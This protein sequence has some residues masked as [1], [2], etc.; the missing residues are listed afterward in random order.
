ML[1]G[2]SVEKMKN[3]VFILGAFIPENLFPAKSCRH[4][5]PEH[6]YPSGRLV[7]GRLWKAFVLS[8]NGVIII[9]SEL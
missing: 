9:P 1:W 3:G 8:Q 7:A 5:V 4:L 6:F 2:L